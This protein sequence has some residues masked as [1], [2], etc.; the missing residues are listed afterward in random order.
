MGVKFCFFVEKGTACDSTYSEEGVDNSVSQQQPHRIDDI[1]GVTILGSCRCD[2]PFVGCDQPANSVLGSNLEF[3]D[4]T[5]AS[6]ASKLVVLHLFSA[7]AGEDC[8]EGDVWYAVTRCGAVKNNKSTFVR[9]SF[10]PF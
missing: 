8:R 2:S 5:A 3:R 1:Q 7:F 9:R 4:E 6:F 10:V